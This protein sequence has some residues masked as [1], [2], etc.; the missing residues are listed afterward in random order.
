ME[1]RNKSV[2]EETVV[3]KE[4]NGFV[5]QTFDMTGNLLEQEFIAVEECVIEVCNAT[6]S[7]MRGMKS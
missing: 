2:S 7:E 4:S 6:L 5:R 3:I 1:R